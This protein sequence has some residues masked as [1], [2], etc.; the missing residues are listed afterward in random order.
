MKLATT[1]KEYTN[2]GYVVYYEQSHRIVCA[3]GLPEDIARYVKLHNLQ[4][5]RAWI[6]FS[7][8][9]YEVESREQVALDH[10]KFVMSLQTAINNLEEENK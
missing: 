3:S 9:V 8:G 7:D 1:I 2:F 6:S 4:P 10:K 5:G